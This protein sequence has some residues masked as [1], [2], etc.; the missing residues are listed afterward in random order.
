MP[1]ASRATNP[2]LMAR[3]EPLHLFLDVVDVQGSLHP[4]VPLI[5]TQLFDLARVASST[6]DILLQGPQAVALKFLNK[7][8]PQDIRSWFKNS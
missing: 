6:L 7:M 4:V 8:S 3:A 1:R 2:A 5:L